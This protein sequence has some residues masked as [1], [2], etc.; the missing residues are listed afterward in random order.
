MDGDWPTVYGSLRAL[1]G[2]GLSPRRQRLI[3]GIFGPSGEGPA[4]LVGLLAI[5]VVV[6]SAAVGLGR[7]PFDAW[8]G[9]LT[10]TALVA[11]TIP[12]LTWL[13]RKEGDPRLFT[14]LMWGMAATVAGMLVRY[15]FVTVVYN[16]SADAGNYA[17]GASQLASLFRQG[18]F[19]TV[20]PHLE[21][22]P[23]ESQRIGLVLAVAYL[24]TG[25]SRWAGSVVFAWLAFGGRLLM[26][27]ALRRAVPEAD[28][29]RYLMLLLF[30]PSLLFWPA[31][32]GKE[33]LMILA[34]G[35][36]SF[37]AA[38]LLAERVSAGSI[39]LFIAGL[40][41]LVF[42]RP[43]LAA[44]GVV[45]LGV[46]S[47]V[48][49]LGGLGKGAQ[50]K[51][52]AVRVVALAVLVVAAVVVFSQTAKVL[53]SNDASG[54]V[55]GVGGGLDK[56]LDQT[57]IGGSAFAAPAV[58]SPL[59]VPWAMV[60][61][62]FR[63]FL[64]EVNG[65]STLVAGVESLI[66]VGLVITSWR[67]LVGGI[68]L[69]LRRPYLVFV[70]AFTGAFVMA[71]SYIGNFG[72]LARQRSI[73]LALVFVFLTTPP[74]AKGRGLLLNRSSRVREPVDDGPDD[75]HRRPVLSHNQLGS[76]RA[77][78]GSDS[79]PIRQAPKVTT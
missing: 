49:T 72:I 55:G 47:L 37:A 54:G 57:S 23:A 59:D 44:I 32:I 10:L 14:L 52:T 56:T 40:A 17:F 6:L 75:G 50:L 51:S 3:R 2:P 58:S 39:A 7:L 61:V 16:D 60:T 65:A 48:G 31:S 63:P 71:F 20:A 41:G 45:A 38:Q 62:I 46:A 27:R 33:A 68:K 42:I 77:S 4:A 19:T 28:D 34:L 78:Q 11:L 8:S 36:V 21:S 76:S 25:T 26:W 53:G 12:V 13:A 43:H 24:F 66:L 64:W 73:M 15:F 9:I 5:A 67:R 22:F 70:L 30:F 29:K 69:S 1:Q 79:P 18:T 74:I 35:I